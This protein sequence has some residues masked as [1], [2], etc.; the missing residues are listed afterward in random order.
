MQLEEADIIERL[1]KMCDPDTDQGDWISQFD[2]VEQGD[3]LKLV[4]MGVVGS[5]TEGP[6]SL[7]KEAD[8]CVSVSALASLVPAAVLSLSLSP[9]L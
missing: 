7:F 9:I 4:D 5:N 1:E 8:V 6:L 2:L 3:T